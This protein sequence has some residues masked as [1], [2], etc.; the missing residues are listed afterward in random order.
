MA[1]TPRV[2]ALGEEAGVAVEEHNIWEDPDAAARVR[3]VA[4]GNEVVPTVFLGDESLVNPKIGAVR[5][6]LA[7][8]DP[9]LEAQER[10][11]WQ[12]LLGR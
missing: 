11:V 1:L 6:L 10:S 2:R 4:D 9:D 12:R 7:K 5:A 8:S 3:S